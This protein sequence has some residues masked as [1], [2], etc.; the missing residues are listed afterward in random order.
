MVGND[1]VVVTKPKSTVTFY[2]YGI[3]RLTFFRGEDRLDRSNKLAALDVR[4]VFALRL[5]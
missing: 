2:V 4:N 3:A 1:G 5:M